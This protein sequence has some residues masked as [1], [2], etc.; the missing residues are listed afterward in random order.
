MWEY[1]NMG[2][3]LPTEVMLGQTPV[4]MQMAFLNK[5]R[6]VD[7]LVIFRTYCIP[8]TVG[9]YLIIGKFQANIERHHV[10]FKP[11]K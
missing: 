3:E 2:T 4:L 8:Y 9:L 5:V 10:P 1:F 6:K 11:N 7:R